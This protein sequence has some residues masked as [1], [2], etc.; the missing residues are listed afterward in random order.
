VPRSP[1]STAASST[2]PIMPKGCPVLSGPVF[3]AAVEAGASGVLV[4]LGDMPFL[5]YAA[6]TSVL[7]AAAA[8][9]GRIV[10]AVHAGKPAHPVWL[11]ARIADFVNR[12]QGDRGVRSLIDATDEEMIA[13]E[14]GGEA[15]FDIDTPQDFTAA[16]AASIS[17]RED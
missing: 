4:L 10:Q 1:G 15:A 16:V 13:V 7:A 6:V 8:N 2:I 12:L 9:P 5:P 14:V 11:P 17:G 3:G